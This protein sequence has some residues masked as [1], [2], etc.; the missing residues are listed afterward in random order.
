MFI[1][2]LLLRGIRPTSRGT[3]FVSTAHTA[4][5]VERT[6]AAVDAAMASRP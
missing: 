5:D 3:W 1:E 2:A 4:A 6:L